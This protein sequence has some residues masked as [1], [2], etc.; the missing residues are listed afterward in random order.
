[1]SEDREKVDHQV[2]LSDQQARDDIAKRLRRVE[3][4][5]RGVIRMVEEGADCRDVAQQM[6]AARKALDSV[7]SR[8]TICYLE[9]ELAAAAR[10]DPQVE[11]AIGEVAILLSRF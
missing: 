8:M 5:L 2:R 6:S 10:Q 7:Y 3:G 11:R 9:Q 4:Q 1:M